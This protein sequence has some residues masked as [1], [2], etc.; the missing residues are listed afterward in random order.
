MTN[1]DKKDRPR[2]P[3]VDGGICRPSDAV[4]GVTPLP[5]T[6]YP[7]RRRA[8]VRVWRADRGHPLWPAPRR[9]TWWRALGSAI[10]LFLFLIRERGS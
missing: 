7:N 10:K 9:R 3:G 8:R 5:N 2:R 1:H 6:V 4:A